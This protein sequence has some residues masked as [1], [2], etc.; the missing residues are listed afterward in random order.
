[1]IKSI[2][3]YLTGQ[4]GNDVDLKWFKRFFPLKRK[5][6]C[7]LDLVNLKTVAVSGNWVYVSDKLEPGETGREVRVTGD[8]LPV[9]SNSFCVRGAPFW[10][11]LEINLSREEWWLPSP[12]DC[13]PFLAMN[14]AAVPLHA[15][16][17]P[18]L[19]DGASKAGGPRCERPFVSRF[20]PCG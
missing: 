12:R 20:C 3:I 1:M 4:K 13:F 5:Q 11:L 14:M 19:R 2:Y 17:G 15:R 7:S 8:E 16:S 10:S 18:G 9:F 6:W